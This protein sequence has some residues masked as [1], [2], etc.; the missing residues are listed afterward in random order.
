[1]AKLI[2]RMACP[3]CG[4]ASA[5]VKRSEG[6]HPY[7]HCPVDG[8]VLQTRNG[9]QAQLLLAK[10]R[11]EDGYVPEPPQTDDPIVVKGGA[12][13]MAAPAPAALT[14]TKPQPAA[15]EPAAKKASWIDQLMKS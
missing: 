1:M 4:F 2:G 10:M 8:A 5:H 15:A 12:Y 7:M 3:L 14:A 13:A 6:K 11:P 9:H